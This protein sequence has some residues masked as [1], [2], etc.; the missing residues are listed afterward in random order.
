MIP[1]HEKKGITYNILQKLTEP[2]I[3]KDCNI[4]CLAPTSSG[5]TIVAEQFILP[6]ITTGKKA[7]Y[8]SPLKALTSEKLS[9]WADFPCKLAAFTSDHGRPGI[10]VPQQMLLMT[11]ECLDSKTRG[12]R[13]WLKSIGVLVSDESHM[14]AMHKRGDA[15]EIGLTRFAKINSDARIIFLS[16]TIPNAEELGNWLTVLNG[17]PTEVIKT[18]WRPVIQ[19]HHFK[20]LPSKFWDFMP[21]VKSHCT[22]IIKE[23]EKKQILIFVHSIGIGKM[24]SKTLDCPFHYSKV[25]K[26]NRAAYEDAFRRREL[27]MMISTS[28]LAYG[29]NLPADV[30]IIVGG[31]RGPAMV[32]P[33]DIKQ[34]AGRIGRYG[35]SEKGTIYYLF[36]KWY[37]D[38]LKK[39]VM[40]IP[41][42]K[43]V[44]AERI[45]FHLVSFIAREKMDLKEI[46]VFLSKTLAAQQGDISDAL[47]LALNLLEQYKVIYRKGDILTVS[48]VGRAAALMYVDPID[49][50][51][52]RRS[53]YNKPMSL[54]EIAKGFAGIPS[55]EYDTYVP[56][57]LEGEVK[58]RYGAQTLLAT[59]IYQWLSG[60]IITD[61][62]TTL[63]FSFVADIE[64]W[65]TAL[66]MT[67]LNATYLDNLQMM[68]KNGVNHQYLELISIPG[69]GRKRAQNLFNL[70]IK[71]KKDLLKNRKVAMNSLGK[72]LYLGVEQR[73]KNPG[74][75]I[76]TF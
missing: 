3:E 34:M 68:M 63:I 56:P 31:H 45:Y 22:R 26:E 24:L 72:K 51:F 33:A 4:V 1:Y 41:S 52:L 30:G 28:T 16:A 49:L 14:L 29:I 19:E 12:A 48:P 61:M 67:K 23:N 66:K 74:R 27:N 42:V 70:G 38:D 54:T 55:L 10:V 20:I 36:M 53:F 43:S 50:F 7:L 11:T 65:I 44:L 15:F 69:I 71:T 2:F 75:V 8:L 5:K 9:Q 76:L 6:M 46:K 73:L 47:D 39:A 35:L 64:R 32:E 13:N 17:K 62:T 58:M 57:E 37:A 59:G 25:T 18:D 60:K 21:A 40:N